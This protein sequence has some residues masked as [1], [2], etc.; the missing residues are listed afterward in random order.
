VNV[1]RSEDEEPRPWRDER[2]GGATVDAELGAVVRR[3]AEAPPPDDLRVAHWRQE[4]LR[5]AGDRRGFARWRLGL[6][7]PSWGLAVACVLLGGVTT[8]VAGM[9]ILRRAEARRARAVE[10][11]AEGAR[12]RGERRWRVAVAAPAV[13]DLSVGDEGAEIAVE[14]AGAELT[15]SALAASLR[16]AAGQAWR[17]ETGA[18]VARPGTAP[19]VAAP[20][21]RASAPPGRSARSAVAGSPTSAAKG[22]EPAIQASAPMLQP[23]PAVTPALA[24]TSE[25]ELLAESLRVLRVEHDARRALRRLDDHERRFPGGALAREAALARVE[26]LLALGRR[27]DALAVLDPLA[28]ADGQGDRGVALARGELRASAGRCPAALGDFVR[29]LELDAGDEFAARALYGRGACRLEAGDTAGARVDFETY[30]RRFP[31]G[32]A[33]V[34]VARAL[35]RLPP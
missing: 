6:R 11:R 26:A 18:V 13:V 25:G 23:A 17:E 3:L 7:A 12:H 1:K 32:A 20:L 30:A 29:V 31:E 10:G 15:G 5:R 28:L 27:A 9:A 19:L 33:R 22:T 14:G 34:P 2:A 35:E 24:G 21:A 8:S 4:V 16:L